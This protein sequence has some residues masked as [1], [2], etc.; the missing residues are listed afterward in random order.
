MAAAAPAQLSAPSVSAD[1]GT[2][3]PEIVRFRRSGSTG[4]YYQALRAA[5]QVRLRLLG[6][7]H[8][9]G[10]FSGFGGVMPSESATRRL[11][12]QQNLAWQQ[13][14]W[15]VAEMQRLDGTSQAG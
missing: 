2:A 9:R 4:D 14:Q 3:P 1:D 11:E 5:A 6:T 13:L 15:I 10:E 8:A 7:L 12:A